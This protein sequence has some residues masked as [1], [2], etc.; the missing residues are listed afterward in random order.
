M[1]I[2][3]W[4]TL[5]LRK[6]PLHYIT[7]KGWFTT[8]TLLCRQQFQMIGRS[9]YILT[10]STA[11]DSELNQTAGLGGH[12][13]KSMHACHS[14]SAACR[15]AETC[16]QGGVCRGK[17]GNFPVTD[18]EKLPSHF[19]LAGFTYKYHPARRRCCKIRVMMA[20]NM[21]TTPDKISAAFIK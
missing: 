4:V 12:V 15:P 16:R 6:Y 13:K 8:L 5:S 3:P 11:P 20:I 21:G 9:T 7:L 17:R 18:T 2:L 19:P 14:V 10:C 1:Y